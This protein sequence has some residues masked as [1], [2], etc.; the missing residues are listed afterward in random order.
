MSEPN[1]GDRTLARIM[2]AN[3]PDPPDPGAVLVECDYCG[4]GCWKRPIEPDPLPPGVTPA[5][6]VCAIR[7]A[8]HQRE[9]DRE[10]AR[11]EA[12]RN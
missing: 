10:R 4:R 8:S 3:F 1:Y 2:E 12:L 9:M 11:R 5:C 7:R 6:T